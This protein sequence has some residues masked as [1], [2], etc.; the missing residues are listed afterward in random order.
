MAIKPK[1]EGS[2]NRARK[3]VTM[4]PIPWVDIFPKKSQIKALTP[5]S[6]KLTKNKIP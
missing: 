6:F 2:S 3:M 1:S 5:L 4:N